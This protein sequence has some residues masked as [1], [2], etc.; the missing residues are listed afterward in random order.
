MNE[1]LT[2]KK[3]KKGQITYALQRIMEY[4]ELE[5]T[6]NNHQVHLLAWHRTTQK[7]DHTA[8]SVFR[9]LLEFQQLGAMTVALRILFHV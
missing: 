1:K 2:V 5:G 6:L 3:K 8:E 9:T 7:S 4:T